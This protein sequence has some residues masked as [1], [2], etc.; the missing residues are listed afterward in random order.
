[1][2]K[3]PSH[4]PSNTIGRVILIAPQRLAELSK[5]LLDRKNLIPQRCHWEHQF[6][7]ESCSFSGTP[8]SCITWRKTLNSSCSSRIV[9]FM[10]A[11]FLRI[12]RIM[13]SRALLLSVSSLQCS[14]SF[15]DLGSSVFSCA[16]S[17]LDPLL[18]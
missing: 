14:V 17:S 4:S 1:M 15:S 11:S 2:R 8:F 18:I 9:A 6:G 10:S 12:C 3:A 13:T 16:F 7:I 5:K